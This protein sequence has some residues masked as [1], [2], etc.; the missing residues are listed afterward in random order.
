[1]KYRQL[2]FVGKIEKGFDFLGYYFSPS[3]KLRPSMKSLN[4]LLTN[5]RRLYEQ[6]CDVNRLRLYVSRWFSYIQAE[7]K[8]FVSLR[9]GLKKYLV[10]VFKNLKIK[11]K[12][13]IQ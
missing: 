4:N 13:V 11:E 5:S 2:K 10:L 3:R 9:G 7:L 6:G 1:M 8:G 12:K